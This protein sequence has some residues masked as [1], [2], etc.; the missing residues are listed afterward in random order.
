MNQ[1]SKIALLSGA[2]AVL[3]ATSSVA[4]G[5]TS[6]GETEREAAS[7]ET[8][9]LI[10]SQKLDSPVVLAGALLQS[11]DTP[12]DGTVVKLQVWPDADVLD[13]LDEGEEFDVPMVG[14]AVT[15]DSGAFDIRVSDWDRVEEFRNSDGDLSFEAVATDDHQQFTYNFTTASTPQVAARSDADTGTSDRIVIKP[16]YTQSESELTTDR[17]SA[18]A[19]L[20]DPDWTSCTSTKVGNAGDYWTNVAAAYSSKGATMKFTY[21]NGQKSSLGVGVS[22]SGNRGSYSVS[23]SSSVKSTATLVYP[24]QDNWRAWQ[25]QFRYSKFKNQCVN[26]WA[27][28]ISTS[29]QVRP[30]KFLGGTK[31]VKQSSYPTA[32]HC[33]SY[34]A[35]SEFILDRT[36]AY[37]FGAGVLTGPGIGVNLTASTGYSTTASVKYVFSSAKKLCGTHDVP[38]GSPKRLV[39]K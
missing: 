10:D 38:V 17:A 27:G 15:D 4:Y 20:D 26:A 18:D 3:L 32:N 13:S 28:I 7:L 16:A 33:T 35:G 5:V 34:A 30:V 24:A 9:G 12:S 2:V 36:T 29:Y 21:K 37:K 1:K 39:A 23:G 8:S 6:G 22:S 11:D 25:T 31:V 14:F 19:E